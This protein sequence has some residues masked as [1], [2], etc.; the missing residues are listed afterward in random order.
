[1][2]SRTVR[3]CSTE[4]ARFGAGP[5]AYA[6]PTGTCTGSAGRRN[7]AGHKSGIRAVD[8]FERDSASDHQRF[9]PAFAIARQAERSAPPN[10][11]GACT[12][13]AVTL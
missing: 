5:F 13:A 9:C 8:P 4:R 12:D 2:C 10:R 3:A 11:A 6:N 7:A 1:M